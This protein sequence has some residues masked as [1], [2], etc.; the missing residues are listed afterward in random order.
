MQCYKF[1]KQSW[2]SELIRLDI[3]NMYFISNWEPHPRVSGNDYLDST[4]NWILE[5]VNF[6]NNKTEDLFGIRI[7]CIR[8]PVYTQL[9]K[10]SYNLINAKVCIF[11][12][13]T[14]S[15][16]KVSN[17]P[18]LVRWLLNLRRTDFILE[19]CIVCGHTI[20]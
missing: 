12:F 16:L 1:L 6:M 14:L 8:F 15:R 5:E 11:C 4:Q 7:N 18:R 19:N 10:I 3:S 9:E 20:N 2:L 13:F 17:W